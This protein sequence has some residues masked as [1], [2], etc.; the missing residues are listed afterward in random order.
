MYEQLLIICRI[1][2]KV[3]EFSQECVQIIRALHKYNRVYLKVESHVFR[4]RKFEN[5][6][7]TTLSHLIVKSSTLAI[8]PNHY[9]KATVS[10]KNSNRTPQTSIERP[11]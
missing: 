10:E 2:T 3:Q 1:A 9:F 11:R 5:S 4:T 8:I 7:N 6:K